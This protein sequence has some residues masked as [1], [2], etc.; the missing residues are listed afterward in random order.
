MRRIF[1]VRAFSLIEVIVAVALFASSVVVVLALLPALTRRG[2]ET[3]DRLVA[4][5][6]PDAIQ[7]EL[8][9]LAAPGFDVLAG[10]MPLMGA[11]P[12][13]GL[14]MVSTRDGSRLQ[15]LDDLPPTDGRMP[16][17]AQYYLI[18][19]WRFPDGPLQ[20][21]VAQSAMAL[22][23]RVSWPYRQPGTTATTPADSRHE[24]IFTVSLNR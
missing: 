15:A 5:R 6:L 13:N 11:P 21:D 7:V 14:A 24:L 22:T 1:S 8:T 12:E 23:V 9:R 2:A 20:Y 10:R 17:Q 3:T 16:E 19:C 4:Q 18:E